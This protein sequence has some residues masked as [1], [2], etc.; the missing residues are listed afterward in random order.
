M[1]LI[2]IFCTDNSVLHKQQASFIAVES[3][4]SLCTEV[5]GSIL[6]KE[7]FWEVSYLSRILYKILTARPYYLDCSQKPLSGK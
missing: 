4:T 5:S 1:P 2:F 3:W 6:E 7:E